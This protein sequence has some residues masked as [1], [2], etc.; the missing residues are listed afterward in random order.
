MAMTRGKAEMARVE[1]IYIKKHAFIPRPP[2]CESLGSVI[3]IIF[4]RIFF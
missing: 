3:Y 4:P 2:P 1:P